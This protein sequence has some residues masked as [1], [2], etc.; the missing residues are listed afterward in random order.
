METE[1]DPTER[2]ALRIALEYWEMRKA[3][4]AEAGEPYRGEDRKPIEAESI[5]E[6]AR[7]VKPVEHIFVMGELRI[8]KT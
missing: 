8:G 4:F 1:V 7:A 3:G 5:G 2:E 6:L